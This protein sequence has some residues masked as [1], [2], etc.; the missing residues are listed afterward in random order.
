MGPIPA[1]M[2]KKMG[3]YNLQLILNGNDRKSL[4]NSLKQIITYLRNNKICNNVIWSLDLDPINL[5]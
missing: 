2:Y 3:Q 1:P 5:N 4:H